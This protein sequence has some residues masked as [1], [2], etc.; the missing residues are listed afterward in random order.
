MQIGKRWAVGDDPPASLHLGI[1]QAIRDEEQT[2]YDLDADV[3][4]WGWTLTYLEG[5]PVVTLDDGT[6]ITNVD[7]DI[8]VSRED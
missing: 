8:E 3:T 6:V 4:T 1:R 2:L 7:G 5:E